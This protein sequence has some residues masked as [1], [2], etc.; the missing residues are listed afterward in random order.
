MNIYLTSVENVGTTTKPYGG[1]AYVIQTSG[2]TG[3]SKLILVPH[4][5]VVPNITDFQGKFKLDKDDTVFLSSPLTFDPSIID[6]FLTL[7]SGATLL[8]VPRSEKMKAN[9]YRTLFMANKVTVLQCTPSLLRTIFSGQNKSPLDPGPL[10]IV[11]VGGENCS[12]VVK[13]IL[14]GL[15]GSGV[16]VYHLYGLTEMSVWQSLLKVRYRTPARTWQSN[17]TI[18]IKQTTHV[19]HSKINILLPNFE[20]YLDR[21]T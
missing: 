21:A 17:Y 2:T 1:L 13:G 10:R 20:Y 15:L 16:A 11:A 8:L 5:S 9:L 14:E 3:E 18:N 12:P 6:I 7:V 4:S 19:K